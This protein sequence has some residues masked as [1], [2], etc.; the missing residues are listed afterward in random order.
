M[1]ISLLFFLTSF[2][3]S[4]LV[5]AQEVEHNYLVGPQNTNCDSLYVH[6]FSLPESIA[7]I[8]TVK[9]RFD[10][11][12][13]L[14]RKQGLQVGEFYSC[15]GDIGYLIIKYDDKETLYLGVSKNVWTDIISSTDP[16]ANFLKIEAS[17]KKFP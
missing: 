4:N 2:F 8:R 13:R 15:D 5:F 17:L 6:G 12:F 1:K 14:T 11:S 7:K 3:I 10:Q 9:F 16:E